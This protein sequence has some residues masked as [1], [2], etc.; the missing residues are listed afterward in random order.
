MAAFTTTQVR[1]AGLAPASTDRAGFPGDVVLDFELDGAKL[2]VAAADTVNMFDLPAYAGVIVK[3]AAI[4]VVRAGTATGTVDI[5]IAGTDV[6][7]LTGWA[8]DAAAGTKLVKLATAANTTVNT[9]SATAIALQ[10]NTAGLGNGKIRV[11]LFC[12]LLEAQSAT[13]V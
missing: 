9:T 2:T 11:R 12:T 3:A 1:A 4:T 7:G 6:T 13:P 5:Q 10:Q 8:T